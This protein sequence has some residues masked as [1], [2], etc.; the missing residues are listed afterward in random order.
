MRTF[1]GIRGQFRTDADTS[2]GE[3]WQM[4]VGAFHFRVATG[5]AVETAPGGPA[6]AKSACADWDS[7]MRSERLGK[8]YTRR[9]T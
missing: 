8:G 7:G 5:P 4:R 1:T 6:A 9:R 3:W 2:F